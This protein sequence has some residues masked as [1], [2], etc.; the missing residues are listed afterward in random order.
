MTTT[1]ALDATAAAYRAALLRRDEAALRTLMAAYQP[2]YDA[3]QAEVAA[4][5]ALLQAD[6]TLS[7]V[8]LKKAWLTRGRLQALEGQ[9]LQQWRQFAGTANDIITATQREAVLVAG[10]DATAL[11]EA[12]ANDAGLVVR[13]GAD[14]ARLN[15]EAT[16]A[17]VGVLQNGSPLRTLLD[18][19]GAD[20]ADT[21]QRGLLRGV[22]LGRNPRQIA[23][24]L[25]T[26]LGGNLNRALT[27]ART[28]HM[29]AY[30]SATLE[31][32]QA[33]GDILRG[34]QWRA[35]PSDRT[36]PLCLAMDGRE[37]GL[38]EPFAQHPNCRCTALPLLRNR[39]APEREFG[40]AWFDQQTQ[41]RQRAILGQGALA[42]YR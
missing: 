16:Q 20:A 40:A 7:T 31:C 5:T 23:R 28:E 34:W 2:A 42:L 9:I 22:A 1:S 27:I 32:F 35:A 6:P 26:A 33:N 38:D 19:L 37:F 39:P 12:A 18:G 8:A 17:L 36:C 30:R 3:I 21:V 15:T 10:L 29:R 41:E 24:D 11:I 25:R 14:L 13:M 4:L